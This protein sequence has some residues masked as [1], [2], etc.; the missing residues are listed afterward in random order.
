[1]IG[2]FPREEHETVP[3]ERVDNPDRLDIA[4]IRLPTIL[5]VRSTDG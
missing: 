4:C 3:D 5:A 1:M 2:S